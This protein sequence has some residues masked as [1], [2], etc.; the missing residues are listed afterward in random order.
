MKREKIKEKIR[1]TGEN[2][3]FAASNSANG[4]RSYYAECFD[5]AR[6]GRLYAVKGG[7]GTGKS[8][9]LRDVATYAARFGWQ[10]EMIYC[11]SDPDSLDGVI[12]TRGK[13]G[14]ALLDA[15][16][17][18]VYEPS[19]PGIREEIVNLGAF[20]DGKRLREQAS[21]VEALNAEKKEAYRMAY[22]YLA[23]YGE[24]TAN[25]DALVESYLRREEMERYAEKLTRDYPAGDGFAPQIAL[26]RSFGMLGEVCLDTYFAEAKR[27]FLIEDCRGSG[28]FFTEALYRVAQN[29]SLPIRV[30][31]DPL[32]PDRIDGLL[33]PTVGE[34]FVIAPA[35]SC[36]Y[37]FRKLS[38]RRFVET[39]RM[40][41]IRG[42]LNRAERARRA[43]LDGAAECLEQVRQ[44]H[45][46]V[47]E[48][49]K[50]AMDFAAKEAFTVAFCESLFGRA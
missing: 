25:R 16:A 24:M 35:G 15:T 37:S 34:A 46:R 36:P 17:P 26:I 31:R 42:M 49:Y 47:E 48:L 50:G 32:L 12:L 41:G 14:I 27:L 39:D 29:K 13:E 2:A 45:F 21:A 10:A 43:M 20:W 30:S 38:M 33:F 28:R 18:H 6:V 44:V 4:F 1:K 22:R 23:G 9:F 40:H 7:P 8:R 11:S 5:V 19:R 3:Y